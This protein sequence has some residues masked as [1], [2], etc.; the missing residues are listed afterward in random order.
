MDNALYATNMDDAR[1]AIEIGDGA[2]CATEINDD[3]QCATNMDDARYA[4][5]IGDVRD[6]RLDEC[7]RCD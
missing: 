1:Y 5:D 7:A 3:A 6:V 4:T 2:Q